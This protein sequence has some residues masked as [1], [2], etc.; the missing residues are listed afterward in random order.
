MVRELFIYMYLMLFSFLFKVAKLFPLQKKIVFCV[1]FVENNYFIYNEL[2]K[3]SQ[4]YP[5]IFLTD[6]KTTSFFKDKVTSGDTVLPFSP[7]HF[8]SFLK[9][10]YHLATS[11]VVVLDNYFG[12]LSAIQFKNEVRKLQIW[13][14]NGAIKTFGW[15]DYSVK[16]RSNRAKKRF[17]RV[18]NQFDYIL[19][20]SKKMS[21]IYQQAFSVSEKRMLEIGIPRTDIFFDQHY[22]KKVK[23][24]FYTK[25]PT[26]REK[27]IIL[28]APTFRDDQG[29]TSDL[30]LNFAYFKEKLK[31][32][33]IL[34]IKLH[35]SIKNAMDLSNYEGFVYDL[36]SYPTMNDL[37]FISDILITDYSSIPFEY[38]FLQKPMIFYPYDLEEYSQ[39]RG[40]WEPYDQ[41]VPGP[42][43]RNSEEI[44]DYINHSS[45]D[46]K[47]IENFHED[48]NTYSLGNA[49]KNVANQLHKWLK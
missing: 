25:Y 26:F 27:K 36:S 33:Y 8:G 1:S 46:Y 7:R 41:L 48:W 49:S 32:D 20:G 42:I 35:P 16:N 6:H 18:Y 19:S 4:T 24:T 40:F 9:G 29:E 5:C 14:A 11:R 10:I 45:F 38:S 39:N 31:S 30:P 3:N 28:Y 23:D 2:K 22:I 43:A 17:S 34:L 12:F 44:V 37:L 21:A 47:K 15:K 13:H